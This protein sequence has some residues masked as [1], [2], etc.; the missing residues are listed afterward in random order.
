MLMQ[1]GPFLA[2]RVVEE[3]DAAEL[4]CDLAARREWLSGCVEEA[5]DLLGKKRGEIPAS[6]HKDGG[7]ATYGS[8]R[9]LLSRCPFLKLN[10]TFDCAHDP[11]GREISSPDDPVLDVEPYLGVM[12]FD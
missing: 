2:D 10:V 11:D 8:M 7:I 9:Y 6:F 3:C 12:L 1:A 5:F 4:P